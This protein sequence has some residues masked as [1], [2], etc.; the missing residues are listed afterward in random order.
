MA[1][2]DNQNAEQYQRLGRII[3]ALEAKRAEV[4]DEI[5]NTALTV[6][7]EKLAE[8]EAG[9]RAVRVPQQRQLVTILFAD[10]SGF[11]AMSETMDH[12][13]VNDVINSLWTR[14]DKAIHDHGGRIDKHIGDAIMALYGTPMA[15]E[16]DPERAIR[17]ALQI[18]AEILEWKRELSTQLGNYRTQIQNIQLRIGIN[19]GPALL[20]TV[21]T[22]GEYTA[23]GDTV[24]IANRLESAA[25]KGGILISHDV[26]QHVQGLFDFTTLDPITLKGRTEPT[27]VYTVNGV[28]QPSADKDHVVTNGNRKNEFE[29]AIAALESGRSLLGDEVAD[30]TL[31]SIREKLAELNVGTRRAERVPQQRKL[32][33]VLFA[34]IS[35]FTAMFESMDHE[36][37]NHV[38]DSLWSRV[39]RAIQD[40]GGRID[41]HINDVVMALYG[42][43]MAREDD[44]E[45][46]I[47]SALQIQ[48]EVHEWKHEQASLLPNYRAQ[49]Q[50]I[51]LRIGINT[52]PALLGTVGTVGEYTAIGDT[53]NLAQRLEASAPKG[54][55]MISHDT[56]QHVRG[57]FDTTTPDPIM[58][59]GKSEPVHVHI[60]NG[61]KPRS[62]RDTTRGLE[63]IETRTIGR[64]EE[65][66]Q[67]QA[68][69][70]RAANDR[71]TCLISVVAEAGIG[72]SRLVF[73]FGKWLD[74]LGKPMIIF[75]GRAAQETSQ[76]P[77]S[78][79][80]GLLSSAFE[81]RDND[82]AAV[83]RQKLERGI[84][85]YTPDQEVATLY[86]HFIGHLIGLDYSN[87]R[88]L[89]GILNDAKQ[90]HDLAFHYAA[91]AVADIAHDQTVVFFLE[92]IHWADSESLTSLMP[93]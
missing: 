87:S 75:K 10:V 56:Y 59:K 16:D 23:I 40:Q 14:V 85:R 39:D 71:I 81:I 84:R 5:A 13:I 4:G 36:T 50:N 1:F 42:I 72:K 89:K 15:R 3:A 83:A 6:M 79:L 62:F 76:I 30:T 88:H 24:N 12:E 63:G 33:T 69:F 47:R 22:V 44:P 27:Q 31:T 67:M 45:R 11:T 8:L 80:R 60:V 46:A 34:D 73:E 92:D 82:R 41:K 29:R 7:R 91:E 51:H 90:V 43:P 55:I 26:Y 28:K 54:G 17:S 53:V 58:V 20:G 38:I 21:G 32:V 2:V 61:V 25:P 74:A 66:A 70:E 57:I 48:T 35:G 37:V 68:A 9:G 64:E 49:I 65:L 78:L 18:Q 77:F 52:G 86:A 93:S 19:I